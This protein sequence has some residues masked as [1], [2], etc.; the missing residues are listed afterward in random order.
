M[1]MFSPDFLFRNAVVGGW[2]VCVMCSVLGVYVALRRMVLLGV[3]LPQAGAAGIALVFF[4]THHAHGEGGGGTHW[5]ALAGSLAVTFAA[6]LLLVIGSRGS[7]TPVEWKIGGALAVAS[8]ATLLVVALNPTG[9]LEMTSLLRGE[10]LAISDRDLAFLAASAAVVGLVFALS[11]R[12]ILL[13]SFDAE[14]ARTI[15]KDPRRWDAVLY[16]LLGVGISVGVMTAGP[17]VVF[18]FLVLPA[19][20]TLRLTS[21]LAA[22]FLV[23]AAIGT[24][25]SLGGFEIAYRADL[26]AGPVYVLLAAA[27]WLLAAGGARLR[28]LAALAAAVLALCFAPVLGGCGFLRSPDER[29]A[30]PAARGSLPDVSAPI[31]VLPFRN[32]TGSSLRLASANPL[33]EVARALGRG[34]KADSLTVL[35]VLEVRAAQELARRGYDVVSAEA[36]H[37]AVKQPPLDAQSAASVAREGGLAGPLLVGT[38]SQFV[39][40][41]DDALHVRLDLWLVDPASGRTLWSGS[42]RRPVPVPAAFTL[43]EVA[44]DATPAIFAEAFA[45]R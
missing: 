10:L 5:L 45:A 11:R 19:L 3:A 23:A 8:A 30:E 17:M 7:R 1:E 13:V 38:L 22:S 15:G 41:A 20:A 44:Q 28:R 25:C 21:N 35:D 26:P 4:V 14:F 43:A 36:V 12:E 6:L 33:D 32:E 37:A 29:A 18:G 9:D 42:A 16:L 40:N 34:A 24:A 39:R 31:A 2:I 27:V